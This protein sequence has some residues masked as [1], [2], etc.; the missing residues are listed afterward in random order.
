M[1]LG[2]VEGFLPR[3]IAAWPLKAAGVA[4]LDAIVVEAVRGGPFI[5]A[6][7]KPLVIPVDENS[8]E[9]SVHGTSDVESVPERPGKEPVDEESVIERSV[10]EEFMT[11]RLVGEESV[12]RE[13][14]PK[15]PFDAESV[16]ERSVTEESVHTELTRERPVN[17]K[18]VNEELACVKSDIGKSVDMESGHEKSVDAE[19]MIERPVGEDSG[20]EKSVDA[21]SMIE[22]LVGEDSGSEK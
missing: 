3:G 19:S 5:T 13:S 20:S 7:L 12:H 1:V 22:R 11:K 10:N 4:S 17:G 14:N 6:T 15:R 18:P 8:D 21:E 2:G 9:E 16:K